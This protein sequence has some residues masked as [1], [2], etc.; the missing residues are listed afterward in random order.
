MEVDFEPTGRRVICEGG[1]TLLEAAQKAGVMLTAICGGEGSCG[2]CVVRVMEGDV[3][4]PT[5]SEKL[6][7]GDDSALDLRLACQ[8]RIAGDVRVHI[9]QDSM[10]ATQRIQTEGQ[11]PVIELHPAVHAV[12]VSIEKPSMTD[13][14][15]DARRLWDALAYPWSGPDDNC[16]RI[17][18]QVMRD[19]PVDL[20]AWNW[21]ACA[22]VR[23]TVNPKIIVAPIN[24]CNIS[25]P[26]GTHLRPEVIAL[27]PT[28]R[29]PLGLAVD[30]GTT[31]LAVYLVDLVKGEILAST[32]A[33]NP[34]IAYGEDVITR[35]N[36]AVSRP[37]GAEQ[38]ASTIIEALNGLASDL[39]A[40]AGH[41]VADIA[42][43]VVVGNTVMHHLFLGLPVK[44]LGLAPYI[45]AYTDPIDVKAREVG[46]GFAKG[47]YVHLLPN[48]AGFVGADHVAML[49]ATGLPERD[50]VVLGIDI[51]TNTEISLRAH[52]RHLAC[53]TASGPAFEGAHIRHGMR[54][55][56]GAIEK[57]TIHDGHVYFRTVDDVAPV[58]LCGSG[59]LDLT[60]QLLRAGILDKRGAMKAHPR[61]RQSVAGGEFIV[62]PGDKNDGREISFSR[63]DVTEIQLVKAAIRAG[64]HTLLNHADV[65]EADIDEVI[66]AGAFGTYLDVQSGIDIGMFPSVDRHCF[67]QVGNA[68]GAGARMALLSVAQRERAARIAQQIEYIELSSEKKFQSEFTR[69]LFFGH[70]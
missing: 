61:V 69:A 65:C 5:L 35:I 70:S 14:R 68:A 42:D 67:R 34:Q 64:I 66:I 46:L 27:L 1:S 10:L 7:L 20:R 6:L 31:K 52:G 48:I 57:V 12:E 56:P 39:C 37:E 25:C 49:L 60:A 43:A 18:I 11:M 19:M 29:L 9:P 2:R 22:F 44:Q 40:R 62:V 53:S 28:G 16:M 21:Q 38:L 23:D 41:G 13:L 45:P 54:A 47:A 15:S 55:A 26:T 32:G 8:A 63:S 24:G 4:P 30:I 3:S 59:I 36:H 58:G 17:D 33:M 50:G 51:G